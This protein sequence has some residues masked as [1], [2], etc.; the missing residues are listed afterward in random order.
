MIN[1]DLKKENDLENLEEFNV[2]V[3]DNESFELK[4]KTAI[5]YQIYKLI[6][7]KI[8]VDQKNKL[9]NYFDQKKIDHKDFLED[10]YDSDEDYLSNSD[11]SSDYEN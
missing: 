11:S 9:I 7:D 2:N 5:Y 8:K 4:D 1:N 3:D 6:R 10:L